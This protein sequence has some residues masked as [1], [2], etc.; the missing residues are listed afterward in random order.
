MAWY[1]AT[2]RKG[3]EVDGYR[4][5]HHVYVCRMPTGVVR[6]I[7]AG[8]LTAVVKLAEARRRLRVC[9]DAAGNPVA[10]RGQEMKW[11]ARESR[12]FDQRPCL[13]A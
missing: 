12:R 5:G 4:T 9:R 11:H 10:V 2:I 7:A 13:A 8:G 6:V 3:L 1:L